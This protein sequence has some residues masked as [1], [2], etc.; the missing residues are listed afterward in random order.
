MNE[1]C[2][3]THGILKKGQPHEILNTLIVFFRRKSYGTCGTPRRK[4]SSYCRSFALS[5]DA[6]GVLTVSLW[7]TVQSKIKP[8]IISL[9]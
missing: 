5:F 6:R 3:S 2:Q 8:A 7:H 9:N 1:S 4:S